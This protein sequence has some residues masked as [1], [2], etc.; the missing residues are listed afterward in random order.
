MPPVL[1]VLEKTWKQCFIQLF[2]LLEVGMKFFFISRKL[3]SNLLIHEVRIGMAL[4]CFILVNN[5][6]E[7]SE[8]SEIEVVFDLF[9]C[10]IKNLLDKPRCVQKSWSGIK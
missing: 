1:V 2:F 6:V 7:R 9:S 10:S 3:C 4:D 5:G 8:L